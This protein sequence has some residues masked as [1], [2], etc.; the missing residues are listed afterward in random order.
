MFEIW[1]YI[2]VPHDVWDGEENHWSL[3]LTDFD[4]D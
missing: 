2:G 1:L 3:Q 4:Q